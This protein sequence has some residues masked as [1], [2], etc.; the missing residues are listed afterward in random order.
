MTEKTPK[1]YIIHES[2]L[3]ESIL[4]TARVKEMLAS[5]EAGNITEAVEKMGIARS[6]FYKYKDG[7]FSFFNADN[8][9]IINISMTVKHKPGVLSSV[10][11]CIAG[12]K[13][14]ILTISQNLPLHGMAYVTISLSVEEMNESLETLLFS[15]QDLPGV[16]AVDLVGKSSL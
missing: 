8:L 12:F 4:K 6:T 16:K 9:E 1:H 7:I 11:N 14:N 3:P 13:G 2:I 5:G 10:L 15:L